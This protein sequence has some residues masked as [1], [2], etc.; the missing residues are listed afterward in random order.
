MS[1]SSPSP[2]TTFEPRSWHLRFRKSLGLSIAKKPLYKRKYILLGQDRKLYE[3]LIENSYN[4]YTV[5]RWFLLEKNPED[6]RF[7]LKNGII[8][9]K[10]ASKIQF[11]RKH[12][13]RNSTCI[14][15]RLM[16]LNLV[17]SM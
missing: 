7:Q 6:V 13:G 8:N 17:R 4:P 14:D 5:Y 16:G 11:K 3:F 2:E 9:Q 10:L 1:K 15:I 12:E